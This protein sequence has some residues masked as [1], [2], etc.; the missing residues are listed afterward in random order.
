LTARTPSLQF[1]FPEPDLLA[2]LIRSYFALGNHLLPLLHRPTFEADLAAEKH[3][4]NES[5]G[6]LVL[7]IC[8]IGSRVSDDPRVLVNNPGQALHSHSAGWIFFRQVHLLRNRVLTEP[9]VYDLQAIV[10][11]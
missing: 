6:S 9:N 8:A 5:F 4:H 11:S 3:L 1:E 2:R 7:V 10:V